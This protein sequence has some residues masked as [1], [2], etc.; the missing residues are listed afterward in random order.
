MVYTYI[1]YF[2]GHM[3]SPIN[4]RVRNSG[5]IEVIGDYLLTAKNLKWIENK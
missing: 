4:H 3:Y 1:M 2:I 5:E